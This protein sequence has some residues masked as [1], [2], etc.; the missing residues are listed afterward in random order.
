M[1][2]QVFSVMLYIM[3]LL[4]VGIATFTTRSRRG[5]VRARGSIAFRIAPATLATNSSERSI[6]VLGSFFKACSAMTASTLNSFAVVEGRDYN[7]VIQRV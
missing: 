2:G 4:S 5:C 6:K 7:T 3:L 1:E